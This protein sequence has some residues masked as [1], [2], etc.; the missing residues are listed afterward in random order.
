VVYNNQI[1]LP[2]TFYTQQ[3]VAALIRHTEDRRSSPWCHQV[4]RLLMRKK[5]FAVT[6]V[7]NNIST[8]LT[9]QTFK[10]C[11][12]RE[13]RTRRHPVVV[14]LDSGLYNFLFYFSFS[15]P[16]KKIKIRSLNEYNKLRDN[17]IKYFWTALIMNSIN[18]I[19]ITQKTNIL[20][21]VTL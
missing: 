14:E 13:M 1:I 12:D 3:Q 4:R 20:L 19:F 15:F 6:V 9:I 17:F 5:F 7:K 11:S 2:E 16:L 10:N 8:S 18:N 21:L